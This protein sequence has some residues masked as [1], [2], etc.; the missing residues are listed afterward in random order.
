MENFLRNIDLEEVQNNVI[1]SLALLRE[2]KKLLD[3]IAGRQRQK[4]FKYRYKVI[5]TNNPYKFFT[6]FLDSYSRWNVTKRVMQR[7]PMAAC[8]DDLSI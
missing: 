4:N 6:G 2:P 3:V 8:N 1:L 5:H 7:E